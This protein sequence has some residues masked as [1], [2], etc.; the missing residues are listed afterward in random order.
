MQNTDYLNKVLLCLKGHNIECV[1]TGAPNPKTGD[2]YNYK[3]TG[4][5]KMF[6]RTK[7]C[8]NYTI[9]LD[10]SCN[11]VDAANA[12]VETVSMR[13]SHSNSDE[14]K[15]IVHEL[16]NIKSQ[17]TTKLGLIYGIVD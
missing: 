15:Q 11:S 17:Y 6:H 5:S 1:P 2:W 7:I 3:I 10:K 9:K 8:D 16:H 12:L 4:K 14:A 13:F